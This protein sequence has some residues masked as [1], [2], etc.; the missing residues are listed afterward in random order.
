M[1][2]IELVSG[3]NAKHCF[4]PANARPGTAGP[5]HAHRDVFEKTE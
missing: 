5:R 4:A 1:N 2:I 3:N